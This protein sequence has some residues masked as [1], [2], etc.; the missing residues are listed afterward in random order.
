MLSSEGKVDDAA[1]APPAPIAPPVPLDVGT[2]EDAVGALD[3]TGEVSEACGGVDC[4]APG[5]EPTDGAVGTDTM[6]VGGVEALV[7][8]EFPASRA[9][10][11]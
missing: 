6:G 3:V 10:A 2:A 5:L 1:G 4:V 8:A 9:A 7:V 11:D